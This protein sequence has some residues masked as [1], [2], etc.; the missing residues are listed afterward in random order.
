MSPHRLP[1]VLSL[2]ELLPQ[3]E[4]GRYA[5]G[6]FS[7]RTNAM[8]LPV[9][10]AAQEQRSPLLVQIAQIELL[11]EGNTPETFAAEFFRCLQAEG[12]N[13]PVG[14]HLDHTQDM[15]LIE[16][17]I[18]AGF[19]SVMIDASSLPLEQNIA[20]TRQ[21]VDYAHARGAAVESELGRIANNDQMESLDDCEL[22]TDAEEAGRFVRETGVD[23][24]AVSVGTAHGSYTVRQP[25]IDYQRLSDIR[26]HTSVHLVLHGG[27]GNP[28]EMIRQAYRLPGGGVSKINI[29]TDL[30][31]AALAALGRDRRLTDEEMS[32]LPAAQL[33]LAQA[34]V[35]RTTA[36]KMSQFLDSSGKA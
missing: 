25:K 8:I 28:A 35:Q 34:A 26:A 29:A 17:A 20:I 18:A 24:L 14:L 19:T 23:A 1:N 22:Y 11:W 3:A 12:I 5:V 15:Q 30:E 33:A 2:K 16:R 21:V 27:S 6:A 4:R 36:E 9:L 32:A 13:V 10:R 7:P 31:L